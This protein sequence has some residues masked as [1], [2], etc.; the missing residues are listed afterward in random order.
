MSGPLLVEG[1]RWSGGGGGT[2]GR[3]AEAMDTGGGG[4]ADETGGPKL[5]RELGGE[6]AFRL[7]H[8][9]LA[10]LNGLSKKLRLAKS[11]Q[12]EHVECKLLNV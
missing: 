7:V 1:M 4:G 10:A 6:D 8:H 3:N 9:G 12:A 2:W 5:D 11:L